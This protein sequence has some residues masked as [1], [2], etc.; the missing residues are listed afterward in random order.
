MAPD[1]LFAG[2]VVKD[3][4]AD[5]WRIGG[6]AYGAVQA[7]KL[8]LN[9]A[10]VTSCAADL[11]PGALIPGVEWQVV[12]SEQTTTFE[13]LYRLG[14]REQRVLG[15]ASPLKLKDIPAEW[16]KTPIVLLAPVLDELDEDLPWQLKGAHMFVAAGAQG[17][18]RR[19]ED[20]IV[21]MKWAQPMAPWLGGDAVF[22]SE[23]D[24]AGADLEPWRS[25]VSL[26]VQTR[27]SRGCTVWHEF[28][29]H[30]VPAFDVDEVDPT[31][32]G[33]VFMTAFAVRY[34]ETGMSLESARFAAA[35]AALAVTKPGIEGI[36]T[37]D[38][39]EA[40][41]REQAAVEA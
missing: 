9:V 23:E 41:R 18:L 16:R 25:R 1:I 15:Q 12:P 29:W 30:D 22:V 2:H 11:D 32:A 19:I 7:H 37:R 14:R 26:L 40:L 4:V 28:G 5:G 38:E 21:H 39:I 6:V 33:D 24:V 10:V 3:L 13:N 17:W 27:G 35:A 20:G 31:G 8:G 34:R 36:G